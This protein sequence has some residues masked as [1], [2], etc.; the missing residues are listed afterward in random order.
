LIFWKEKDGC[1]QTDFEE[2][3]VRMPRSSFEPDR[4]EI[5]RVPH[6][7]CSDSFIGHILPFIKKQKSRACVGEI[8]RAEWLPE[9]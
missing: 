3:R 7:V 6:K 9:A 8:L 2:V 1:I 5:C 4:V